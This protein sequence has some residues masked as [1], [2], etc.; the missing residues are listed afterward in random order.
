MRCRLLESTTCY[1]VIQVLLCRHSEYELPLTIRNCVK[2]RY[3]FHRRTRSNLPS[4]NILVFKNPSNSDNG[5]RGVITVYGW[6]AVR[7]NF[8]IYLETLS[9]YI[10]GAVNENHDHLTQ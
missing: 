6:D 10:D 5:D 4:A 3:S 7:S 2:D 8:V 9:V 1:E